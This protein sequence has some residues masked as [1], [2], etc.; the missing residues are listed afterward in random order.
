MSYSYSFSARHKQLTTEQ[1]KKV[2][3][4]FSRIQGN[5]AVLWRF[6]Y[7][8]MRS[9]HWFVGFS[10]SQSLLRSGSQ[11]VVPPPPASSTN[12]SRS[13]LSVD[14]EAAIFYHKIRC[15]MTIGASSSSLFS[16]D[17]DDFRCG[18]FRRVSAYTRVRSWIHI[19][20]TKIFSL[21]K[22]ALRRP[23]NAPNCTIYFKIFRGACLL[24]P[25]DYFEST[26]VIG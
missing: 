9:M 21:V 1:E 26:F 12:E 4:V 6:I 3:A 16:L 25:L 8:F 24:T 20:L 10:L 17:A 14:P 22:K 7:R 13:T 19:I 11:R 5:I 18:K 2:E 23:Q 15:R